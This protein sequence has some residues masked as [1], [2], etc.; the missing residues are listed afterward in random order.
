MRIIPTAMP[1][2]KIVESQQFGDSRGWF[3]ET[4]NVKDF[5]TAGLDCSFVQDNL[6]FSAD[7]GVV[8]GL[9]YQIPPFAQAKLV[10]VITGKIF[11]VSVDLRRDSPTFGQHVTVELDGDSERMLWVPEGFAHGFCTLTPNVRL[12]YK[13]SAGYAPAHERS[14][15]W[16]DPDLAITWPIE[17]YQAILS[18]KDAAALFLREI[19]V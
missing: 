5:A 18:D 14:I 1:D 9:H 10:R 11:D 15:H 6:S 8:R 7:K 13:V 17:E 4:W 16:R 19:A 3:S 12:L 2:V